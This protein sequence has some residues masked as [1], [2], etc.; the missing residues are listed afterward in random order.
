MLML[1]KCGIFYED[2]SKFSRGLGG[3][4]LTEQLVSSCG[5]TGH[6]CLRAFSQLTR[7]MP[8]SSLDKTEKSLQG[9]WTTTA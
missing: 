6:I 2:N 3:E 9:Q 5:P 7:Q 8:K 1:W 4:F